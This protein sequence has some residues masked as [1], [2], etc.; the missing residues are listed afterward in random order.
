MNEFLK[1]YK[2]VGGTKVLKQYHQAHVLL[3]ALFLSAVLGFDKKS[4][5]ILRLAVRNKILKR[6]RKKYRK[7]INNYAMENHNKENVQNSL[8]KQNIWFCWLQGIDKAPDIV[9]KCYSSIKE[10]ILD[11]EIVLITNENYRNYITF[12]DYIEDKIKKEIIS[13]THMSDLLRLELL[14]RYGGTWIDATVYCSDVPDPFYLDSELFLFQTLKPGLDGKCTSI[15]N[16]FITAEKN[17]KILRLTL[18]LLYE[19]WRTNNKLI[20]YFIFHDFFQLAIETYNDEWERVIPVSNEAPHILQLRMFE[21]YDDDIWESIKSQ[22]PFHKLTY[23]SDFN[24]V[25]DDSYY[26][27]ILGKDNSLNKQ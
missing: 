3:Y 18:N 20:D 1:L 15:S 17:N 2:K 7:Y 22:T 4:L 13:K 21:K 19:Y 8:G 24:N 9:K 5:E 10:H 25:K 26:S 16:W 27:V 6:L 23:K 12:P 14:V 11:R